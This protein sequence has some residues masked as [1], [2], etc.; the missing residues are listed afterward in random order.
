MDQRH[1]ESTTVV[2]IVTRT[3]GFAGVRKAWRAEP[4]GDQAPA[5]LS[6]IERCPWDDSAAVRAEAPRSA[7]RFVWSIVARWDDEDEREALLGDND[8]TGAW[9]ELV[10]A[11]RDWTAP[12]EHA[13]SDRTDAS[14]SPA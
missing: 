7:D 6:L 1:P 3:G 11:V 12:G 10:D 8:L 14:S 4:A 2:V 13:V 5:F 9:R